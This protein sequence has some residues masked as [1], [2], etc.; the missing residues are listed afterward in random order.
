MRF[1]GHVLCAM[2]SGHI[3][4]AINEALN[5]CVCRRVALNNGIQYVMLG[6]KNRHVNELEAHELKA[7]HHPQA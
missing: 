2:L 4:Y 1:K 7:S 6:G 3:F 5:K